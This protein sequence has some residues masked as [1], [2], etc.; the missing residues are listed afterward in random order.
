[1]N[2][3]SRNTHS[4]QREIDRDEERPTLKK[5]GY[6]FFWN[7]LKKEN[8]TE[9]MKSLK[10]DWKLIKKLNFPKIENFVQEYQ[11]KK[12]KKT[13]EEKTAIKARGIHLNAKKKNLIHN[14]QKSGLSNFKINDK[15]EEL[16]MATENGRT[17]NRKRCR[18]STKSFILFPLQII[19][20]S[21]RHYLL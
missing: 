12:K 19:Y 9:Q 16:N 13:W 3:E 17:E 6:I 20:R 21:S 10:M 5:I 15:F 4:P 18:K 11:K 1:M 14:P 8:Y 2:I 7:N